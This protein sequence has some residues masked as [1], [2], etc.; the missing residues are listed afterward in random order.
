MILQKHVKVVIESMESKDM[1]TT[2]L[3]KARFLPIWSGLELYTLLIL[4]L[5]M[6]PNRLG[7]A[8]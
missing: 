3:V 1:N 5:N 7:L 8:S 4:G 6:L 2:Q